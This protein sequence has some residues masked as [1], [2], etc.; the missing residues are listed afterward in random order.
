M[1][2]TFYDIV[3]NGSQ[4]KIMKLLFNVRFFNHMH[5]KKLYVDFLIVGDAIC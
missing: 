2:V 1:G 4:H 5:I 3:F